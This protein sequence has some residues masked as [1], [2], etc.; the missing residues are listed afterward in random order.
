MTFVGSSQT[1][2]QGTQASSVFSISDPLPPAETL[3]HMA[4]G[5]LRTLLQRSDADWSSPQQRQAVIAVLECQRD[6]LAI[7]ATG[8]GKT[9]LILIPVLVEPDKTTVVILPLNSLM[10]DLC[11]RLNGFSIP[12]EIFQ[13]RRLQGQ[14]NLVVVSADIATT[15]IWKH[16]I[17]I[18]D[19]RRKVVRYIF[20][21]GHVPLSAQ[22]YRPVLKKVEELR[23]A[24]PVQLVTL[25]GSISKAQESVVRHM[26]CLGSDTLVI[27]T[28]TNRPELKFVWL[29]QVET[30]ALTASVQ[31]VVA[32]QDLSDPKSR[33]LIFVATKVIGR[34]ISQALGLDFYCGGDLTPLERVEYH[35]RWLSGENRVMVCTSAF[36]VGNDYSH[37]RFVIHAGSPFEMIGYIQ[38]VAR[39]G[40]DKEMATCILIPTPRGTLNI[41]SGD[42]DFGGKA[43]MQAALRKR[44]ECIR[45][46]LTAH[47]DP[48][49]TRCYDD[50]KNEICSFC[51][52]GSQ[53][54]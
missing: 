9:M 39:A 35:N 49:G 33:G 20:D 24:F 18:V 51:N 53:W 31:D 38:E 19:S 32:A 15:A 26:F 8:S 45:Y 27:R 3:E 25:S 5:A 4:L 17:S 37:T 11:R 6:V 43:A 1:T 13:N 10:D 21:E 2:L 46:S 22:N 41:S 30:T 54:V 23:E 7:M 34:E 14:S 42:E 36:G 16:E 29:P 44:D 47:I 48:I 52:S 12:Y 50:A 28:N 40:R